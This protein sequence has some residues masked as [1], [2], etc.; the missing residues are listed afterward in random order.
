DDQAVPGGHGDE[1]RVVPHPLGDHLDRGR[2]PGGWD[3]RPDRRRLGLGA[4][5]EH[6]PDEHGGQDQGHAGR[7]AAPGGGGWVRTRPEGAG[8]RRRGTGT[9]RRGS[10]ARGRGARLRGRGTGGGGR[11]RGR[12]GH[13]H[14]RVVSRRRA[15]GT[16][17]CTSTTSTSSDVVMRTYGGT[18]SR[19]PSSARLAVVTRWAQCRS[20]T[21]VWRRTTAG[22]P[23]NAIGNR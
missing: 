5:V 18:G 23:P 2:V 9:C 12:F 17:N 20:M 11:Q 21:A 16:R 6:H 3:G 7:H 8:T 13:G 10:R 19:N 15:A 22:P 1:V 14:L 4:P